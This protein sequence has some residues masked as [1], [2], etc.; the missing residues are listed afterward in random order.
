LP[1][2]VNVKRMSSL[3]GATL[4]SS[5]AGI[6]SGT[7]GLTINTVPWLAEILN[8]ELREI[9]FIKADDSPLAKV[10]VSSFAPPTLPGPLPSVHE[11]GRNATPAT[12]HHFVDVHLSQWE[13]GRLYSLNSS[14]WRRRAMILIEL[15]G[16]TGGAAYL[17]SIIVPLLVVLM[18]GDWTA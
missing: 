15:A 13:R 6:I 18:T 5:M 11:R 1:V 7:M 4:K 16:L 9:P 3:F 8:I 17:L 12:E 14:G 10:P 2:T